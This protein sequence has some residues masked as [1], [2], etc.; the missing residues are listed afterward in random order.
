MNITSKDIK[1]L[2]RSPVIWLLL[3]IISF[4]LAWLLW[5]MIDRY[6]SMQ[7]S[8]QSLPNPPTITTALWLPF[9][10]TFAQLLLLLVAMTA[11]YSFAMERSQRTLWYLLINRDSF[12]SVVVAKLKA[13]LWLLVFVMLH[14]LLAAWLLAAGG[15]LD[16]WQVAFGAVG[17]VMLVF[18]LIALGQLLS[19]YCRSSGVAILI[20]LVVFGLLWMLG[21]DPGSQ[22]YGL[23]WLLLLSP[24]THLK[25]L[26]EGQ[27]AIASM[28]YFLAGAA[29]FMWLTAKQLGRLRRLL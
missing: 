2:W 17:L 15:A 8:F 13:Q 27:V 14:L 3:A 6:N 22:G 7:L 26:C 10:M 20:N 16:W 24:L 19:S 9:V 21:S 29:V 11:G 1:T 4:I 12:M 23:N 18:W 28:L 25:W 5:Q